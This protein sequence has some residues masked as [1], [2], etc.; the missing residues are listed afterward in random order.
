MSNCLKM[1]TRNF[2]S[3]LSLT[4]RSKQHYFFFNRG[5][6]N[7]GESTKNVLQLSVNS[8]Y[9]KYI[10]IFKFYLLNNLVRQFIH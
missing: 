1:Q 9:F 2:R 7:Q 10:I 4:G 6:I 3:F 5:L 8:L